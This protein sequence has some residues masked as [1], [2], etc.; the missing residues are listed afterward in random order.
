MKK[1]V[2][3]T[4]LF[5][6]IIQKHQPTLSMLMEWCQYVLAEFYA[7]YPQISSTTYDEPFELDLQRAGKQYLIQMITESEMH[8]MSSAEAKDHLRMFYAGLLDDARMCA[9]HANRSDV[10]PRDVKLVL[11]MTL[12]SNY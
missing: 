12:K 7:R 10:T 1:L 4:P 9:K 3:M 5:T 8:T 6:R 2:P 11:R